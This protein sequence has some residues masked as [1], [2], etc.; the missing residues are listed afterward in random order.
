MTQELSRRGD[1]FSIR[2]LIER[3]AHT[4]DWL[5][6]CT[7]LLNGKRSAWM[8]VRVNR[9]QVL[10]VRI[11]NALREARQLTV[12]LRHLMAEIH[13]QRAALP[14]GPAEDDDLADL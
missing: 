12:E 1:P 4:A 5:E 3:A 7:E 6:K 13:R 2:L 11:D 9:D 14:M 8:H 10:E